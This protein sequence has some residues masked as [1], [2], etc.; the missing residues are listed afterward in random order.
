MTDVQWLRI[1]SFLNSCSGLYVGMQRSA[2]GLW[3][4]CAG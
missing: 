1:L 3:Q 2:V 4:R